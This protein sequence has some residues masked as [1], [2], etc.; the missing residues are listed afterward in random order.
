MCS[1]FKLML[2]AAILKRVEAGALAIDGRLPVRAED[3]VPYAS[4]LDRAHA[5]IGGLLAAAV[6]RG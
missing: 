5:Q 4:A 1:T 2:V 3:M 6:A